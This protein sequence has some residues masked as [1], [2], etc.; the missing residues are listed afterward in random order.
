MIDD[1]KKKE[2]HKKSTFN[3]RLVG[4][5]SFGMALVIRWEDEPSES[6]GGLFLCVSKIISNGTTNDTNSFGC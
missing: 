4:F 6:T 2:N 3:D 5:G 1:E